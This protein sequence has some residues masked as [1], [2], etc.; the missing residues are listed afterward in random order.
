MRIGARLLRFGMTLLVVALASNAAV[1]HAF[2]APPDNKISTLAEL[3]AKGDGVADDS[4]AFQKGA[5]LLAANPGVVLVG[6]PGKVYVLKRGLDLRGDFQLDLR[7]AVLKPTGP[8]SNLFYRPVPKTTDYV[9]T[10][11]L[12]QGSNRLS[13][14]SVDG[15]QAGDLVRLST[16]ALS[17]R[18]IPSYRTIEQ[19]RGKEVAIRRGLDYGYP[20]PTVLQKLTLQGMFSLRNG[21]V[22]GANWVNPNAVVFVGGYANVVID[23]LT[24][25]HCTGGSTSWLVP[26]S[27]RFVSIKNSHVID[28]RITVTG[29]AINIWDSEEAIVTSN[30]VRGEGFGIGIVRSDRALVEN[31]VLHGEAAANPKTSVRGIKLIACFG[32]TIRANKISN[33]ADAIKAEDSGRVLI[34]GNTATDIAPGDPSSY[35]IGVSNQNPDREHQAGH[36]IVHNTINGSGGSGIYLGP[37]SPGCI[38][39]DNVIRNVGSFGIAVFTDSPG[40]HSVRRNTVDTFD[41]AGKEAAGI[42]LGASASADGNTI[43]EPSGR[44]Q[45][46][47]VGA[48]AKSSTLGTNQTPRNNP[49]VRQ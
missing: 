8:I 17:G 37:G 39:E 46:I 35:A 3:G 15:L 32:A 7:G 5:D 33:Y 29:E 34:E 42:Y 26:Q 14:E 12:T 23:G 31:N 38:V 49:I 27:N 30:E 9:V 18:L 47:R 13:L 25:T 10:S 48:M 28:N 16:K 11:G 20:A 21:T 22:D 19:V 4:A 2:A 1:D 44:K 45:A 36:R 6:E 41:L 40:D 24:I 43:S